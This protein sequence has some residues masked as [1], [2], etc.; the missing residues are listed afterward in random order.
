MKHLNLEL[1]KLEQR[2]A[3]GAI[4]C[5]GKD[6]SSDAKSS[7]KSKSDTKTESKGDSKST[8][9]SKSNSTHSKGSSG[10]K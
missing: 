8:S 10:K 3:P 2:I 1:E 7:S 5:G 4:S 9:G 6:D